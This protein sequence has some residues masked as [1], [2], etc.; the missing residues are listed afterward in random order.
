[1]SEIGLFPLGIVLLPTELVPL[2][3]FEPR[4]RELISECLED[5]REFGLILADDDEGLR[6]VGT[7]A[8][9]TEV[10]ERFDDGRLN[11]VVEGRKRFRVLNL[12][13]G[14]SFQTAEVEPLEDTEH[15]PAAADVERSLALFTKLVEL[16]GTEIETPDPTTP[17]LSYAVAARFEFVPSL[18]QELLEEVS[19]RRRLHRLCELLEGAATTLEREREIAARAATNGRVDPRGDAG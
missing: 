18:K 19:E 13:G 9:V 8:A 12:T 11:V 7:L 10:L 5:E 2:H 17:Q 1:M 3:I 15:T 16:T 6:E 14:R 4:Y